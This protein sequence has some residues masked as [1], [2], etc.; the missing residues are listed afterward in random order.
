MKLLT[1]RVCKLPIQ[2]PLY[3]GDL[4]ISITVE[5]DKIDLVALPRLLSSSD[6]GPSLIRST[7]VVADGDLSSNFESPP[8]RFSK[9]SRVLRPNSLAFRTLG[10]GPCP[11]G[12]WVE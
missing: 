11:N 4:L 12:S 10:P 1:G 6:G 3:V 8:A 2:I 5:E 7:V 9:R